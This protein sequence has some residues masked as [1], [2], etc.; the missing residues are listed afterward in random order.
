[1]H[2]EADIPYYNTMTTEVVAGKAG[3]L[4]HLG[5]SVIDIENEPEVKS[6]SISQRDCRFPDENILTVTSV[7]SY[8]A[9]VTEC[10]MR[11][12]L[13]TCNCTS[14]LMPYTGLVQS[15]LGDSNS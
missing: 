8:S 3:I 7:Y 5:I 11:E 14:H 9:C 12:Q 13:R 4:K 10:R 6:L 2:P 1:M 15:H